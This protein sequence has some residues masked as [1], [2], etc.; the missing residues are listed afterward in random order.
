MLRRF[1]RRTI[2]AKIVLLYLRNPLPQKIDVRRFLG[3]G[4]CQSYLSQ[5]G[6]IIGSYD[7]M[8]AAT[9]I[10]HG[11]ALLTSN[12]KEFKRVPG[13]NVLSF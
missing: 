11:Y 7:S 9:A 8:I 4:G 12:E 13:L 1:V 3:R 5:R 10:G 6:E 2:L